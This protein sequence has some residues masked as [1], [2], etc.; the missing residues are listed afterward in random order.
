[1]WEHAY[2]LEH[3]DRKGD[4]VNA[5]WKL[6]DWSDVAERFSSVRTLDLLL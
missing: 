1:M 4:W 6:V 3:E 2:Y 5:F